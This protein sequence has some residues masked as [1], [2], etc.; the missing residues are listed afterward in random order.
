MISHGTHWFSAAAPARVCRE[1]ARPFRRLAARVGRRGSGRHGGPVAANGS[2][3]ER[4]DPR[5]A[6]VEAEAVG[7]IAELV[8][9][10][11][12]HAGPIIEIGTLIGITTTTMALAKATH[13]K[14]VTVDA[15]CW[16]PWGLSPSSHEALAESTL[17]YLVTT[18]H[19]ERVRMDKNRFYES[20]RGPSP[21]LVFLDAIH[22][23]E[24]TRK[25]IEWA[26]SVGAGIIAGHD[27]CAAFPGVIEIV[28]ECGGPRRLV[29]TAWML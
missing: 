21:A 14:I 17:R 28:D 26:R 2:A 16:N 20:Y 10:S 13:Q 3:V 4:F 9:A 25:D 29:G 15:Y 11:R 5:M 8:A 24:E 18:G 7:F 12:A 27:Y 22:D 1:I 6:T 23:Y 19:V